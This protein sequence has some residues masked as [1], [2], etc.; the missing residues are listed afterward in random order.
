MIG[1][2]GRH[3][4]NSVELQKI[5]GKSRHEELADIFVRKL[6]LLKRVIAGMGL[7]G[8]DADDILQEVF[9]EILERPG[10]FRGA[11]QAARWLV[12]VTVNRCF[13]EFRRRK[14]FRQ[15]AD[16]ILKHRRATTS[17]EPEPE[18]RLLRLEQLQL[19]REALHDLDN[20]LLAPLAL[21]YFCD[22]T[23]K[24]V[25]EVLQ[26]NHSTVR[27]HLSKARMILAARLRRRGVEP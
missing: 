20:S 4:V 23:S 22:M 19:V 3:M 2:I 7:N 18:E 25:G 10:E 8:S 24:E 5:S 13:T 17:S 9:V 11:D 14:R 21:R 16:K 6:G 26:L 12:R 27:G 1:K 15:A